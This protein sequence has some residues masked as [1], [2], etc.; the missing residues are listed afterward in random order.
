MKNFIKFISLI[1]ISA[2]LGSILCSFTN[3]DGKYLE[4][5][6]FS[7]ELILKGLKGARALSNNEENIYIAVENK[8]LKIDRNNNVFLELKEEGNIYDLEYYNG[9]LYY[10]LDEKLVS[11]N[12]KSSEREV[13]IEDIPNKGINK[14]DTRILINEGKLYLTIGTST[15]SG[16]VDEEGENPDIP[17]VDIVLS[18]RNYDE[19][20]KGAF[21]PYNTKTSKGEKIKGNILGNGAIIELDIES[22]K[23][24][25]YSYGIRNVKGFDLNS[26]GEIFAIVGGIEDEGYRPLSGDSDYIY[27][28]EGKGTWYGWPDYS[29]GDP[30]NSPRFRE[31]GKPIINFVTDAHKSYVMPKPLYQSES[32]GNINTLLIDREGT[33][34]GDEN[35]FLFFNNKNNTLSKLL[36]EGEVKE[37]IYLDKNSYINDMKIIWGNLYILDGNKGVL[38]RLEKS[39]L[40]DNIPIYNYFVI[41]GI[42]FIFIGVLVIKFILSLKK[43]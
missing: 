8:I 40:T 31:E 34:L 26:S 12:I 6:S 30:V 7:E 13:L 5:E 10:T 37:L 25:L 15:N 2:L 43:K 42:N 39:D 22:K 29:G 19:N 28:I 27:K 32:V 4:S 33:I 41:L 18:G 36:K 17:P 24:Q 14:E 1:L 3:K 9:F 35:S 23:K 16:I 20:K 38:F 11:Y 21:V